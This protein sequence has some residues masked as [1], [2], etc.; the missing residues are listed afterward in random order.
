M[1]WTLVASFVNTDGVV[2]WGRGNLTHWR[3]L[4]TFGT[5][6][7]AEV[8]DYKGEAWS[9]VAGSEIMIEDRFVFFL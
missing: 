7:D 9:E 5:P 8:A 3:D 4:D 1:S 6:Q 2:S